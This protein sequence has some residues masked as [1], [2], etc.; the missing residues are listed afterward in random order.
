MKKKWFAFLAALGAGVFFW[1]KKR[2]EEESPAVVSES[3]P[4]E[5][6]SRSGWKRSIA[7]I[8]V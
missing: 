3:K 7:G 2:R 1:R 4:A 6:T 5:T 8:T